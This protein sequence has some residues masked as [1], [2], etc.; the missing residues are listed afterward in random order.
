M[1]ET[2]TS[3][4]REALCS[5]DVE[6]V[7]RVFAEHPELKAQINAPLGPFDSPLIIHARTP[8][9]LDA[10]LEAG[11]D[12]NARST[13]WAG[14]FGILDSA[15]PE[16]ARY[17][18]ERGARLDAHSAARLGMVTELKQM[19]A[20]DKG[21][22]NARGGDGQTPLHF[23]SSI[24]VAEI[25]L[26]SGAD[27]DVKDIDHESTPAQWMVG[28]RQEVA[29]FLV[30]RGCKSDIFLAAALGNL[31]WVRVE[32]EK[33]PRCVEMRVDHEH[34]PMQNPRAGGHIYQWTL[35]FHVSPA[36]VASKFGHK[37][38][39]DFLLERSTP[40]T[41][42]VNACWMGNQELA[43]ELLR[44]D[45]GITQRLSPG[46]R[47]QLAHAARNNETAAVALMLK[48]GFP[49]DARGQHGGT[50][51]HWAA[52]H[53]NVEMA[54]V[55]LEHKAPLELKDRDF[56]AT[57]LGWAN[58]GRENGWQRENGKYPEVI[59]VLRGAGAVG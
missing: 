50:A 31:E 12:I 49:V 55:L 5:D 19:L 27:P 36:Q 24:E 13:W 46:D 2:V 14:S 8:R 58:H 40:Q 9:M 57:P 52:W 23:A 7:R 47:R 15:K 17:A 59:A 10:F 48:A 38:V 33:D 44:E 35:G 51:L 45:P 28:E 34:F 39:A 43:E 22:A 42:L 16:L 54:R 1:N 29:R 11:A 26:K 41:R 30:E 6:T 32:V 25:L 3:S 20:A 21:L 37:E 4:L 18:I 56:S 53:G